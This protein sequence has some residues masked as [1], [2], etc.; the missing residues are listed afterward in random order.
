MKRLI[1]FW[2]TYETEGIKFSSCS[3]NYEVIPVIVGTDA[4]NKELR[5]LSEKLKIKTAGC[6]KKGTGTRPLTITHAIKLKERKKVSDYSCG[7][8]RGF[9]WHTMYLGFID[10]SLN[11]YCKTK[12]MED[13][14]GKL[15]RDTF[16]TI[17][18]DS[19]F[20][21]QD[22]IKLDGEDTA[23]VTSWDAFHWPELLGY[24]KWDTL[25]KDLEI[26]DSVFDDSVFQCGA[27]GEWFYNDNGHTFNYRLVN[28]CE[29]YCLDCAKDFES[30]NIE[31]YLD[32]AQKCVQSETLQK[33]DDSSYE[34]L[35]TFITGMC[36]GRGGSFDGEFTR[37]LTPEEVLKEYK[38]KTPD[39][40]FFFV[41]EES[42]QFQTYFS[43]YKRIEV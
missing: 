29:L 5:L 6:V 24:Q 42:G 21:V 18:S 16:E 19:F 12:V 32:N 7:N 28:K 20:N 25:L 37:E 34:K 43:I 30:K 11:E 23:L 4:S 33:M 31:E 1:K 15:N 38:G 26:E 27:C 41:H 36:D 14:T 39:S 2:Q 9:N 13:C 35:E 8:K 10:I 22:I 17:I 3:T 40:K